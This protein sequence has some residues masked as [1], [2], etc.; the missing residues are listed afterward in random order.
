MGIETAILGS[1]IVGGAVSSRNASKAAGAQAAAAGDANAL[2]KYM[3]DQNREDLAPYREAGNNAL[4]RLIGLTN[5]PNSIT[6]Q[7]GYQFGLDQGRQAIERS[8]AARGGLYSG[9]TMKALQ[10]FGSDYAGTKVNEQ[11]NRLAS[12]AGIGQQATNQTG[13]Y[14]QNYATN[15]GNNLMGASNARAGS[16]MAQGNA[17][18]NALNTGAWAF[19][20]M[21]QPAPYYGATGSD[22]DAM[23]QWW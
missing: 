22:L 9:A 19:G 8:A 3:Y 5:D 16:Y 4:Q 14:G 6:T 10:R 13:A 20:R 1:A 23:S 2:Q 11:Y 21:Q 18:Q 7:P 15:A 12:I 17:W